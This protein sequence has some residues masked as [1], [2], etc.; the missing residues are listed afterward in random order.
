M[1]IG[2]NLQDENENGE[3]LLDAIDEVLT[4]K[5]SNSTV[6]D[7]RYVVLNLNKTSVKITDPYRVGD[8]QRVMET[9]VFKKLLIEWLRRKYEYYK[10]R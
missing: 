9:G 3:W 10:L 6:G 1:L 7:V 2:T 5:V 4:G 8:S